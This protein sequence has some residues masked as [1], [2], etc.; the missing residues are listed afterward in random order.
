MAAPETRGDPEETAAVLADP[1]TMRR[2]AESR[3]AI[4]GGDVLN[5][6][7]LAVLLYGRHEHDVV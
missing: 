4:A 6:D 7:E 3:I 5:A 1:E 2:L